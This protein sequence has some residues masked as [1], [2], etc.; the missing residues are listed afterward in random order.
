M[1]TYFSCYCNIQRTAGAR[2]KAAAWLWTTQ[3]SLVMG[4]IAPASLPPKEPVALL[5]RAEVANK[6]GEERQ[7]KNWRDVGDL[8]LLSRRPLH[9]APTQCYNTASLRAGSPALW[10]F[11]RPTLILRNQFPY[12]HIR[13][14]L[15]SDLDCVIQT[16]TWRGF[17]QYLQA[18]PEYVTTYYTSCLHLVIIFQS[19][20]TQCNSWSSF[21]KLCLNQRNK[22]EISVA[23]TLY[24]YKAW[25]WL[26]LWPQNYHCMVQVLSSHV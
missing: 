26:C 12:V 18:T 13:K 1:C 22:L 11:P 8:V 9:R 25:S 4:A 3:L 19:H 23:V 15:G 24:F 20:L 14:V 10:P 17:A 2:S 16:E 7:K 5:P 21:M 6:T